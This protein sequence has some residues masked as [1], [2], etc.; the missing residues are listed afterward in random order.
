MKWKPGFKICFLKWV[1]LHRYTK[2]AAFKPQKVRLV[3]SVTDLSPSPGALSQC[4]TDLTGD[5]SDDE[6]VVPLALRFDDDDDGPIA[7]EAQDEEEAAAAA[8]GGV[9]SGD[10][11]SAGAGVRVSSGVA[12]LSFSSQHRRSI[13]LTAGSA[14]TTE[15]DAQAEERKSESPGRAM[16]DAMK[17]VEREDAMRKAA[18]AG[19]S[20][21][22]GGRPTRLFSS[23]STC[24]NA[25][26]TVT[27]GIEELRRSLKDEA[28][29]GFHSA[30]MRENPT[31]D[32]GTPTSAV[33]SRGSSAS[34]VS[35]WEPENTWP[36]AAVPPPEA[37][38]RNTWPPATATPPAAVAAVNATD[39][40]PDPDATTAEDAAVS[41]E[42]AVAPKVAADA[43]AAAAAVKAAEPYS[44]QQQQQ[45]TAAVAGTPTD[46]ST[47]RQKTDDS[48][49]KSVGSLTSSGVSLRGG[50]RGDGAASGSG[51]GRPSSPDTETALSSWHGRRSRARRALIAIAERSRGAKKDHGGMAATTT[52][53]LDKDTAAELAST[54]E[55]IPV[56]NGI[57]P[58]V[59]RDE[60]AAEA[61]VAVAATGGVAVTAAVTGEKV[62]EKEDEEEETSAKEEAGVAA[63]AEAETAAAAAASAAAAEAAIEDSPTA[64]ALV[65]ASAAA[66]AAALDA[67]D[68]A[69][70][71]AIAA[72]A[73][74]ASTPDTDVG[75]LD[76]RLRTLADLLMRVTAPPVAASA[77]SSPSHP[78]GAATASTAAA[79]GMMSPPAHGTMRGGAGA[80]DAVLSTSADDDACDIS[81]GGSFQQQHPQREKQL[82]PSPSPSPQRPPSRVP[83]LKNDGGGGAPVAGTGD[84]DDGAGAGA[85]AGA[86]GGTGPG[87]SA[88]DMER[89]MSDAME[90]CLERYSEKLIA[91]L[92]SSVAPLPLQGAHVA[93]AV[94]AASLAAAASGVGGGAL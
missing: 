92:R 89:V 28:A 69:V 27:A 3:R 42:H 90:K 75:A 12:R 5:E 6:P 14:S 55:F 10:D 22:V 13:T 8:G 29:A 84:G 26:D 61:A 68:V 32:G 72:R 83:R 76:A 7:A 9:N 64:S 39:V 74:A 62:E 71:A 94:A 67:L 79:A 88:L 33:V 51:D 48:A 52:A 2:G 4:P 31:F 11:S 66:A 17:V 47:E 40:A 18:A 38:D 57:A 36:P 80:A 58:P 34:M 43:A 45:G 63:E 53:A 21:G 54:V 93:H 82:L 24:L 65:S 15:E 41:T 16:R 30:R 78:T 37:V 1:N 77:A 70:R 73:A 49:R 20:A 87:D 25:V 81:G 23:S 86:A 59:K 19:V 56:R 35:S 50:G 46:S 85:G 91:V 44:P 60:P